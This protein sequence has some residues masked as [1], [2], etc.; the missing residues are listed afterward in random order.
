MILSVDQGHRDD[1]GA[2]FRIIA[3]VLGNIGHRKENRILDEPRP[4]AADDLLV[5]AMRSLGL[6]R[7]KYEKVATVAA[8]VEWLVMHERKAQQRE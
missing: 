8:T 6:V 5:P 1:D 4:G 7:R 2:P 3:V